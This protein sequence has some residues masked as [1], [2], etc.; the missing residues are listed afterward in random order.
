MSLKEILEYEPCKKG[1]YTHP[2]IN[3]DLPMEKVLDNIAKLSFKVSKNNKIPI[4]IGGEHTLSYGVI[5]GIKKAQGLDA[6]EIGIIQLDAHAD[7]RKKYM[8]QKYSH[9]CV[10]Y[11]LASQKYKILQIG[12]RAISHNEILER[13]N[14]KIFFI[15]NSLLTKKMESNFFTNKISKKYLYFI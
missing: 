12:V 1:I 9:A 3:C 8:N 14:F 4:A 2:A 6:T 10:M 5:N 7:L 15:D 13:S 11:L